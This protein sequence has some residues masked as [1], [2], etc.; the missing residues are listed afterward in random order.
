MATEHD[1]VALRAEAVDKL[2]R[3]IAEQEFVMKQLVM[4]SS[5]SAWKEVY[6]QETA[7]E[8]TAQATAAIRGVPRLAALPEL[9]LSH[10]RKSTTI[11]KYGGTATI[12]WEDILT[13]EIDVIARNIVKVGRAIANSVDSVI[14]NA[15]SENQSVSTINSVTITAG[16][17]WN[18][19]T[20]ANRDPVQ[21]ILNAIREIQIDNLNPLN[22]QGYLVLSPTDFANILGNANIRNVGQFYTSILE[23]GRVG[24]L[25]G[26]TVIVSNVVTADYS[27][28]VIAKECGTWKEV[29]PLTTNTVDTPPIS[30]TISA[31]TYGVP[32]LSNPNAVC[33]ISNTQA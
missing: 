31:W 28:V 14:W 3:D 24:R 33:L 1:G 20:I 2:I 7:G 19:A 25:L 16:Q 4:V 23:N 11:E 30:R 26:L 13:A 9:T 18:S 32:Q 29:Q 22:G 12:S 6:W 21:N 17:E 8:L 15:L 27:M 10:T 5:S